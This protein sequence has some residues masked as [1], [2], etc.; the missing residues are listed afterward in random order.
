MEETMKTL[1]RNQLRDT[2]KME[3]ET[4]TETET[5]TRKADGADVRVTDVNT[6]ISEVLNMRVGCWRAPVHL[7]TE[8]TAA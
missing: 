6:G 8:P 2:T 3:T 4:E 5:L 7:W 1:T